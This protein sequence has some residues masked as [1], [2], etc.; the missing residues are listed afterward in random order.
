MFSS[1]VRFCYS[2]NI[3]VDTKGSIIFLGIQCSLTIYEPHREKDRNFA[4]AKA[5]AQI[6]C[7]VTAQLISALV[8]ATQIEQLLFF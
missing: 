4:Y 2:F 1:W 7:A 5:N 3:N 8:F 6:S